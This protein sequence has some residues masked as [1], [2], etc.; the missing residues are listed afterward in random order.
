MRFVY[1]ILFWLFF[2][3]SA[4][5]DTTNTY[6]EFAESGFTDPPRPALTTFFRSLVV[7]EIGIALDARDL[8]CYKAKPDSAS[9]EVSFRLTVL[10]TSGNYWCNAWPNT[11]VIIR[12]AGTKGCFK[13]DDVGI[14]H[15]PMNYESVNEKKEHKVIQVLNTMSTD[16]CF[17]SCLIKQG[18]SA[19]CHYTAYKPGIDLYECFVNGI[20]TGDKCTVGGGV[21]PAPDGPP[22]PYDPNKPPDPTDPKDP[23]NPSPGTG[24]SGSDGG[25]GVG[26][27][28][29]SGGAGGVS[30]KDGAGGAGG[31]GG[32]GGAG[33]AGGKGGAGG[34]GG[35]GIG[36]VGG[37]GG[38][39]AGGMSCGGPGQPKCKIDESGVGGGDGIWDQIGDMFGRDRDGKPSNLG[40]SG[41]GGS[42]YDMP[43]LSSAIPS[44]VCE[45]PTVRLPIGGF[46]ATMDVCKYVPIASSMFALLWQFLFVYACLGTLSRAT[47]KP[48][49]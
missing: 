11:N 2:A 27:G 29:G 21:K 5:A 12:S 16:F 8:K 4:S 7:S 3:C 47:S 15:V 14:L 28:G 10:T 24:G 22:E 19:D 20:M 36:G 23:N 18:G 34:A 33:G 35:V 26:G 45:N 32:T 37:A 41:V 42:Y 13:G 46:S 48:I 25:I 1:L 31:A 9:E 38:A 17:G 44:G 40:E 6:Y 43:N 49:T 39:G 30:G